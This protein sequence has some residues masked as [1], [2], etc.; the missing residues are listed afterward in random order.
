MEKNPNCR[1]YAIVDASSENS[2]SVLQGALRSYN[3]KYRRGKTMVIGG[4]NDILFVEFQKREGPMFDIMK[5]LANTYKYYP[6]YVVEE[7]KSKQPKRD[8]FE[9][10]MQYHVVE[11][12][13]ADVKMPTKYFN[14]WLADVRAI[15][16]AI[17]LDDSVYLKM[18]AYP[19]EED[20]TVHILLANTENTNR[21]APDEEVVLGEEGW[22]EAVQKLASRMGFEV[23]FKMIR[24]K[25]L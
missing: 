1:L 8:K 10:A 6:F 12:A 23:E 2:I 22:K 4:F 9:N 7:G 25:Y 13:L 3:P 18:H 20:D 14:D 5:N 19:R 16:K 24:Y 21:H 11:A 15:A 17:Y